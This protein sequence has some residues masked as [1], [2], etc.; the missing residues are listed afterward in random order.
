MSHKTSSRRCSLIQSSS[1][2]RGS[3]S[4]VNQCC[5]NGGVIWT[6]DWI[7]TQT[8][9]ISAG[10]WILRRNCPKEFE[11]DDAS[12]IFWRDQGHRQCGDTRISSRDNPTISPHLL[13]NLHPIPKLVYIQI[14]NGRRSPQRGYINTFEPPRRIGKTSSIQTA[15]SILLPVIVKALAL[16]STADELGERGIK[17]GVPNRACPCETCG[18]NYHANNAKTSHPYQSIRLGFRPLRSPWPI[19]RETFSKR[20][21]EP[22][23]VIVI[24]LA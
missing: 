14:G 21:S 8:R 17:L 18:V 9:K 13:S 4:Y 6:R 22:Y 16:I 1:S 19:V 3:S 12:L 11:S 5:S 7:N 24:M 2:L 10:C 23:C 20:H 15:E